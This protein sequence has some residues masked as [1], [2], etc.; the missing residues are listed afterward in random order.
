[1]SEPKRFRKK[2]V[3]IE[4]MQFTPKSGPGTG[5]GIAGW[6]GGRFNTDVKPS[7][8][9]DV[10]YTISIP[11]LEGIMTADEGDWIIRGVQGEFYPIKEAIFRETYD[12]VEES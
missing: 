8:H 3:V 5:Y 1:M 4:A 9:T 6:C 10:R 7:D 11:T 12:P 2:P